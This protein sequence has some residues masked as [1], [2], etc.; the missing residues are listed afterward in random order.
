MKKYLTSLVLSFLLVA[1]T[2][3]NDLKLY[4]KGD[5]QKVIDQ[6]PKRP[7][8]IHFWGVTCAPCVKEMPVWG[9]FTIDNKNL[10]VIYFQ[11][12][13]VPLNQTQKMIAK[14]K[15][16]SANNYTVSPPFD[17]FLRYEIH[18]KW[19]GET[20]MTL[21]IDKQNKPVMKVGGMDFD[22]LKKQVNN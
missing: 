3:A 1:P 11:V 19:R 7:L 15:L 4:Q 12:D 9:K 2:L 6:N 21:I 8:V 10:N 13:N 17:E 14:A 22:W 16:E 20:P 18:P 5:W